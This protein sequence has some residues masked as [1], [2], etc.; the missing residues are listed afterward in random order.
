MVHI[1]KYFLESG[2]LVFGMSTVWEDTDG[3]ANQYRCDLP[4]Y[5]MHLLSSS[6]GIMMYRAINAP[7][8]GKNFVDGLNA[9]D[10]HYLKKGM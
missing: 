2:G 1:L 5:L 4:I 8:N 3:C 9:S 7:V 6:C 10:K